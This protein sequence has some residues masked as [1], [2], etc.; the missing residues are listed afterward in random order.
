MSKTQFQPGAVFDVLTL[1]GLTYACQRESLE[2]SFGTQFYQ[3]ENEV[4]PEL[5]RYSIDGYMVLDVDQSETITDENSN[6]YELVKSNVIV[7]DS[8]VGT[9]PRRPR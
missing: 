3:G 9:I 8:F 4:N 5:E 1:N 2:D 7:S 6:F